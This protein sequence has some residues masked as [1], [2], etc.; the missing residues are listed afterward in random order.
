MEN[1]PDLSIAYG[2]PTYDAH[3]SRLVER[4][5]HVIDT[6]VH[7]KRVANRFVGYLRATAS[8]HFA[9]AVFD[10]LVAYGDFPNDDEM[11]FGATLTFREKLALWTAL[12]IDEREGS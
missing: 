4:V 5:G 7:P 10:E 12:G 9:R 6:A 2:T 3:E 11:D 8:H 1:E